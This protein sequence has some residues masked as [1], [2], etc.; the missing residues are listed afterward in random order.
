[1]IWYMQ[2]QKGIEQ[3]R[4]EEQLEDLRESLR[5]K[6]NEHPSANRQTGISLAIR[7]P[8]GK[9]MLNTFSC[10][11]TAKVSEAQ[12]HCCTGGMHDHK[13]HKCECIN[14]I[15]TFHI[16]TQSC[17]IGLVRVRFCKRRHVLSISTVHE[18][19]SP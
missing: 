16:F 5:K 19:A 17:D 14:C 7:L 4:I 13:I 10:I 6:L 11:A 8:S 3:Q 15:Y 12:P 18:S 9:K 1:M 2:A